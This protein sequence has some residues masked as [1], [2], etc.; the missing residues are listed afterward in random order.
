MHTPRT[1]SAL[2]LGL[3]ATSPH[4]QTV[5]DEKQIRRG[6]LERILTL[7]QAGIHVVSPALA[8]LLQPFRQLCQLI[9]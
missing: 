7:L 2:R 4:I 1:A 8:R 5:A 6:I 9:R 3:G